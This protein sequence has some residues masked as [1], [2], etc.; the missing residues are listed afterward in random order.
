VSLRELVV[1]GTA[2]QV[3]TRARNHVGFVLRWDAEGFLFDPGEATQ[4][5]MARAG[6]SAADVHHVCITHLHG[7]HCLGLPGVLARFSLDR[8]AHPVQLHYP[9]SGEAY[10]ERLRR[11]AVYDDVA[12]V[13]P[14]PVRSDGVVDAT[15]RWTLSARRLDHSVEAFGY[16]LEEPGGR[17]FLPDRLRAMGVRGPAVHELE[18]AGSIRVGGRTVSLEEVSAPRPG[19]VFALIMDTRVCDAAVELARDADLV[20]IES[21]FLDAEHDLADRYQHLTARQAAT[22]AREAGARRL[23][24][25]HYSQRHPDERVFLAEAAAIHPDVI[26]ARDLD[27]IEVPAR[28]RPVG[29]DR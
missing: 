3:P 10:I 1:L 7:D 20:V 17:T 15:E 14:R 12:D 24:L 2:A 26:A 28:V 23:V 4:Q 13:R 8:V 6:V 16:R 11:A 18:T 25:A 9:A 5:Q 29:G 27:R 22:I 21:T 19:Q